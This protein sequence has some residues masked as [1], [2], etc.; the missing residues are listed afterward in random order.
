MKIVHLN[1][2]GD[3][4][5][6]V[7]A[8]ELLSHDVDYSTADPSSLLHAVPPDALVVD[9]TS[10]IGWAKSTCELLAALG[11][12]APVLVVLADGGMVAVAPTWR[13]CDVIAPTA[14]PAELE[15]RLRLAATQAAPD[16]EPDL[17][18]AGALTVDAGGYTAKLAGRTLD[19]T[20]KEFALLC[21][22]AGHPGRVFTREQLLWEIWGDD[23][24]GGSRT[25][26]VHV[27]RLRA[28]LGTEYDGCIATVWGVGYRFAAI[29]QQRSDTD[30]RRSNEA[31]ERIPAHRT[32]R[33]ARETAQE[34]HASNDPAVDAQ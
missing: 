7:P 34:D 18:T 1:K 30:V 12:P 24:Y 28:K 27:R 6:A 31:I 16:D 2:T 11:T 29:R 14:G 32:G 10:D 33:D 4:V 8:L 17:I 3:R 20:Y 15:A 9:G 21:H 13:I 25:V 19:L 22:L 23:Y 26:D 5:P